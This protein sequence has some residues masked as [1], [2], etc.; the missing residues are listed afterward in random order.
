LTDSDVVSP[1]T[2]NKKIAHQKFPNNKKRQSVDA[3]SS[4]DT[5]VEHLFVN[6]LHTP[7]KHVSD[8]VVVRIPRHERDLH[9]TPSPIASNSTS[10]QRTSPS[11]G[12]AF[13]TLFLHSHSLFIFSISIKFTLSIFRTDKTKISSRTSSTQSTKAPTNSTSSTRYRRPTI[14]S[15]KTIRTSPCSVFK[16]TKQHKTDTH[17]Y[18]QL[19][20]F[21]EIEIH[22]NLTS[23]L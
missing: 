11:S 17:S 22:I 21:I 9:E 15:Q 7:P 5:G 14:S 19:K 10:A 13:I 20:I 12:L 23:S 2:N 18:T 6:P 1:P 4:H 3:V 16:Q 8:E